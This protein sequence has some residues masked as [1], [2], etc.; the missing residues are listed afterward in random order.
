MATTTNQ[1]FGTHVPPET[2]CIAGYQLLSTYHSFISMWQHHDQSTLPDPFVLPTADKLV[3][4]TLLKKNNQSANASL[5][6][7]LNNIFYLLLTSRLLNLTL[8]RLQFSIAQDGRIKGK[9]C[10]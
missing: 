4:N 3:N 10:F 5:Y 7:S 1:D 2:A 9:I 8:F 6:V